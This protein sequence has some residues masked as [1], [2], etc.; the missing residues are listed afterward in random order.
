MLFKYYLSVV[1]CLYL[2]RCVEFLRHNNAGIRQ[3][4][5]TASS[6]ITHGTTK[7]IHQIFLGRCYNF[8]NEHQN[9]KIEIYA[10]NYN[11]NTIWKSFL[12]AVANKNPCNIKIDDFQEFLRLVNHKIPQGISTFWSGTSSIA[13][14]RMFYLFILFQTK[15]KLL[16]PF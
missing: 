13:H 5:K 15:N 3:N 6:K 1:L 10:S 11:C 9:S 7:N 16:N 14:E 8:L 2:F 4:L 12:N